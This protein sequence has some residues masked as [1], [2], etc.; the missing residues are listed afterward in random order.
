MSA[1][2]SEDAKRGERHGENHGCSS[3]VRLRVVRHRVRVRLGGVSNVEHMDLA[4]ADGEDQAVRAEEELAELDSGERI[5]FTG[6]GAVRGHGL[7]RSD[8][9]FEAF[10]PPERSLV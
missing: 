6:M 5:A 1:Q 7:Q 9:G 3:S 10:I 4:G 2:T 8:R